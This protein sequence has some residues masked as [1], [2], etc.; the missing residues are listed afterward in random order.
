MDS[1]TL[2]R[3]VVTDV[4][5]AAELMATA[6]GGSGSVWQLGDGDVESGLSALVRLQASVAAVEA[7]LLREAETRDLKARTQASTMV[8][9]LGDRFRLSRAEA[10]ARVRAAEGI[11]RHA[12]V[13]AGLASGAVT[14]E[15]AEVLSGCWTPSPRCPGST[16]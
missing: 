7:M 8:R 6:A 2:T 15:Q 3:P 12:V 10:G 4:C 16:R 13:Q 1:T 5:A 11:G 14:A 9:W